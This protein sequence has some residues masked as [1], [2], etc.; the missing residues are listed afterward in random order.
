MGRPNHLRLKF[1]SVV[2][3]EIEHTRILD[4]LLEDT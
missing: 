4:M 2:V 3:L 1:W